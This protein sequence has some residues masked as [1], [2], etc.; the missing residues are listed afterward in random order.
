MFAALSLGDTLCW[1]PICDV[2]PYAIEIRTWIFECNIISAI[3]TPDIP[4]GNY[5]LYAAITEHGLY[6]IWRL[7]SVTI[8][9]R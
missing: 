1:Y 4:H 8:S 6:N 3:C 5:T 9:I 2:T 7:D